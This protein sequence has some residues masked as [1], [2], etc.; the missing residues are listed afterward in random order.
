MKERDDAKKAYHKLLNGNPKS[1]QDRQEIVRLAIKGS[2]AY[3]KILSANSS[4][5]SESDLDEAIEWGE[6]AANNIQS[7]ETSDDDDFASD[8]EELVLTLG[9]A[10]LIQYRHHLQKEAF[11]KAINKYDT[12]HPNPK[13]SSSI[14]MKSII[15]MSNALIVWS[16]DETNPQDA[17]K[18]RAEQAIDILKKF[19]DD[20]P[21]KETPSDGSDESHAFGEEALVILARAHYSCFTFEKNF[22]SVQNALIHLDDAIRYNQEAREM[23][24][25]GQNPELAERLPDVEHQL[26]LKSEYISDGE[27]LQMSAPPTHGH[28]EEVQEVE[29]LAVERTDVVTD[30]ESNLDNI[31]TILSDSQKED[32]DQTTEQELRVY[33]LYT[34]PIFLTHF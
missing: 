20:M 21:K 18:E 9:D 16:D 23:L 30:Q 28:R 29:E 19:K 2:A 32:V 5:S 17:R 14:R 22:G 27:Q 26:L 33:H 34:C 10:Y 15:K 11:D 3:L 12:L 7:I 31:E 8:Y 24:S 4:W 1:Q 6:Q 13:V 25:T